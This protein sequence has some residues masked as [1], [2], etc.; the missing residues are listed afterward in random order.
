MSEVIAA[1]INVLVGSSIL[2]Y[3]NRCLSTITTGNMAAIMETGEKLDKSFQ[4]FEPAPR[5]GEPEVK[6]RPP[7]YFLVCFVHLLKELNPCSELLLSMLYFS[8][9]L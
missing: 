3:E 6:R 2:K 9:L 1:V 8:V 5:R 4:Q 7:D